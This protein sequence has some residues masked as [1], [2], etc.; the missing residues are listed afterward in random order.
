MLRGDSAQQG[1]AGYVCSLNEGQDPSAAASCMV[2]V[3]LD[4][5]QTPQTR[6]TGYSTVLSREDN[7]T[8]FTLMDTCVAI[9]C[10]TG[11][12]C[13]PHACHSHTSMHARCKSMSLTN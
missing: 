2:E 9:A 6:S 10:K 12:V 7:N 5:G 8:L 1:R 3:L 4:D 11:H 13:F